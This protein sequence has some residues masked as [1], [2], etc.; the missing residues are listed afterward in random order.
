MDRAEIHR[1]RRHL[2][3]WE[4]VG[5]TYFITFRVKRG[6]LSGDE[7]RIVFD[8]VR[9]GDPGFYALSA[10]VVMPDHVHLLARPREGVDLSRM[11]KGIKGVAARLVNQ[12]RGTRGVVWQDESYDRIMRDVEEA[13]NKARYIYENP[14]RAGLVEVAGLY[15]YGFLSL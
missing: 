3:H 9:S 6:E 10:L 15:P 8:H 1:T 5:S 14:V 13:I 2:P 12:H 7:R 4:R 11:M